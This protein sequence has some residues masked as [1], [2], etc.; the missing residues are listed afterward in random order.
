MKMYS[1][2]LI[3]YAIFISFII[4]Y[5]ALQNQLLLF[6]F[7]SYSL[8]KFD[9]KLISDKSRTVEFEFLLPLFKTLDL[10]AL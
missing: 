5:L 3:V 10:L 4:F 8:S 6:A 1:I 9:S 7:A 2:L